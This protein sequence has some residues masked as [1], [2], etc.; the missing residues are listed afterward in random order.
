MNV[1]IFQK[2][3]QRIP[4]IFNVI[5]NKSNLC[6]LIAVTFAYMFHILNVPYILG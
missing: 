4:L 1:A 5:E 2:V 3:A 6:P